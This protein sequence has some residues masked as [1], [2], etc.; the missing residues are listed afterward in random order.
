MRTVDEST[1]PA[2]NKSSRACAGRPRPRDSTLPVVTWCP[3]TVVS[4]V[5][6]S[7]QQSYREPDGMQQPVQG[8]L[9][10]SCGATALPDVLFRRSGSNAC[11]ELT[12]RGRKLPTCAELRSSKTMLLRNR[13]TP[14]TAGELIILPLIV[15]QSSLWRGSAFVRCNPLPAFC[16]AIGSRAPLSLQASPRAILRDLLSAAP[17]RSQPL[18]ATV[19]VRSLPRGAS[20][21]P[22]LMEGPRQHRPA[23]PRPAC[24][25]RPRSR[26]L[27]LQC[28][29]ARANGEGPQTP[30]LWHPSMRHVLQCLLQLLRLS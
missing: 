24:A 6:G 29:H 4:L 22:P 8:R 28:S 3:E 12:G 17:R 7:T 15:R 27:F 19:S 26:S 5:C 13:P 14:G 1:Q 30:R 2:A 23:W 11:G 25:T 16:I 21:R 20:R 18:P 10:W 9:R